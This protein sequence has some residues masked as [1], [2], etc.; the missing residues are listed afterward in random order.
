[1]PK[2]GQSDRG[3][4]VN[5]LRGPIHKTQQFSVLIYSDFEKAGRAFGISDGAAPL[6]RLCSLSVA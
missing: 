4:N 3:L 6:T 2:K 5:R 1:M